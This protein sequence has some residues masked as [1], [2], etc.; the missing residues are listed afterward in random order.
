MLDAGE[1]VGLRDPEHPHQG[2]EGQG[3]EE[4][5]EEREQEQQG[6]QQAVQDKH[7]VH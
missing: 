3:E 7:R 6:Q 5:V 4:G 1:A 2:E